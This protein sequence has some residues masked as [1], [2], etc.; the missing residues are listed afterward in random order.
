MKRVHLLIG[1]VAAASLAGCASSTSQS[2]DPQGTNDP[3]RDVATGE[4]APFHSDPVKEEVDR[5]FEMEHPGTLS[6]FGVWAVDRWYDLWDVLGWDLSFGR[7]LGVNV[8]VT[9]FAQLG[10]NWWDGQ[11]WGQRGRAWG[12]WTTSEEDRGIG[13]FYWV[14]HDR[15]PNWGTKN[16]FEH[17][18]KYTGWD[19]DEESGNKANHQD[20]TEVGGLVHLI[21]IGAEVNV[22]PIEAVDFVAGLFPPT[23]IVNLFGYHHPL[24]D[25]MEDDTHSKI[26]KDLRAEKG[27]GQ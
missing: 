14:E 8:H 26:E 6:W 13:P 12:V 10:L 7:G 22:S 5:Q 9:E 25:I 18:Y 3:N 15:Q 19:L 11:S 20:W 27:L 23:L 4:R 2:S 24:F 1:A 17:E 21:A 16:L